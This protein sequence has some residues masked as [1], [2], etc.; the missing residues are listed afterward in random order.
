MDLAA[1]TEVLGR[2]TVLFA[3]FSAVLIIAS[4]GVWKDVYV[5]TRGNATA[6]HLL[7]VPFVSLWLIYQERQQIFS[8]IQS[9]PRLAAVLIAV[10]AGIL[11]ACDVV[12]KARFTAEGLLTANV[13]AIVVMW[14]GGFAFFYGST[15]CRAARF[16]LA[17]LIFTIPIPAQVV[18]LV[19]EWLKAGS[20]AVTASLFSVTGTPYLREGFVFTLPSVVIEIADE[21]SGIRSSIGL[22]LTMLLAGHTFLSRGWAQWLLV[23]AVLPAAILKNGIRIVTLT[24]LSIHVDPTFLT[25]ELHHEGGI[26]FFLLTLALLAP[27][28]VLLRRY[29]AARPVSPRLHRAMVP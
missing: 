13:A 14:I 26:F 5:F 15:A 19:T 2:R 8:S 16:P 23:L 1:R 27:L 18:A 9:A 25:G 29:E 3:L 21:C 11:L 10:S 22:F 4:L 6:S 17:F 12:W 24:L 28:L 20:A 7:L